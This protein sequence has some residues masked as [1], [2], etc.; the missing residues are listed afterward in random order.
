MKPTHIG[1]AVVA[2][3]GVGWF[4]LARD[5]PRFR[6]AARDAPAAALS[7]LPEVRATRP[8]SQVSVPRHAPALPRVA[9][10]A[11]EPQ[12]HP[13]TAS[14]TRPA[15]MAPEELRVQL[16]HAFQDEAVDETWTVQAAATARTRMAAVLP[17]TSRLRSIEC[18]ASMCRLETAHKDPE[19]YGKFLVGA[20]H[21]PATRLWNAG[22]FSTP[23]A[24]RDEEGRVVTVAF[25]AREGEA[26]PQV[27]QQE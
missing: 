21:D 24:D 8:A 25:L 6:N 2:L 9:S 22:G 23:L 20:F 13:A 11:N 18:R 14:E 19:S 10:I 16:D 12:E 15:A 3:T 1:I 5:P 26:L 4:V 7:S 27:G 17:E